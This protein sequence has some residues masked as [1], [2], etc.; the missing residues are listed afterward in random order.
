MKISS[1][2]FKHNKIIPS[3]YTCDG[4]GVNPPLYFMEIPIRTKSLAL[5]IS[6][7]DAPVGT[8]IHWLVWNISPDTKQLVENSI[9]LGATMGVN[10]AKSR[11]Y[12]GPCPPK[13]RHRYFFKIYALDVKLR[14]ASGANADDFERAIMGH[15]LDEAEIVGVYRRSK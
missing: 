5:I 12:I 3:K 14:L 10:S 2:V 11:K 1:P 15:V 4:E 7:P 8:W 13:G 6:D 9:P